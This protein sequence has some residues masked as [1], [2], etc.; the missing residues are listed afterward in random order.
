MHLNYLGPVPFLNPLR[1]HHWG[2]L[3]WLTAWWWAACLSLP[4]TPSG[5]NSGWWLDVCW[6][7]K[8]RFTPTEM[9]TKC[10]EHRGGQGCL[11]LEEL[12]KLHPIWTIQLGW[13]L[14]SF[15]SPVVNVEVQQSMAFEVRLGFLSWFPFCLSLFFFSFFAIMPQDLLIESGARQWKHWV[16]IT[17]PP[18]NYLYL[19]CSTCFST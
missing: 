10:Y 1:V 16:L 19:V 7:G 12:E 13:F 4:W 17:E 18:G 11:F 3:Q 2:Q 15:V 9:F 5:L 14:F 6:H 8:W